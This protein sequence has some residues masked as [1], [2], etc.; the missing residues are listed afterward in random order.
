M[1]WGGP[2]VFN[3]SFA[4]VPLENRERMCE[5]GRDKRARITTKKGPSRESPT[6]TGN[7]SW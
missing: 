6:Q 4:M 2:R 5:R 1:D 3:N 7:P